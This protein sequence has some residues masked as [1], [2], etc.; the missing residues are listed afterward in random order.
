MRC[1][2]RRGREWGWGLPRLSKKADIAAYKAMDDA[3]AADAAAN[4]TEYKATSF[5]LS[6]FKTPR[7]DAHGVSAHVNFYTAPYYVRMAQEIMGRVP[8]FEVLSDVYACAL[9]YG[10]KWLQ[11]QDQVGETTVQQ[12]LNV[13]STICQVAE[14]DQELM[15]SMDK[16]KE[17]VNRILGNGD[18]KEAR[19]VVSMARYAAEKMPD[20]YYRDKALNFIEAEFKGL[21]ENGEVGK[22]PVEVA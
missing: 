20:G 9:H 18:V 21:W 16:M 3:E 15:L 14:M 22:G 1:A 4:V 5:L 12:Q 6:K 19:R 2:R 17:M 7:K 11:E 13:W 8:D 10:L